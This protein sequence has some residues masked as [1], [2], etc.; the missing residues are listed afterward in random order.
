MRFVERGTLF[1]ESVTRQCKIKKIST[2]EVA[3]RSIQDE[4]YAE[5]DKFRHNTAS[6]YQNGE[7]VSKEV[8]GTSA[9][10]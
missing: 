2:F 7:I 4:E 9:T 1:L 10:Y 8:Q 5:T 3:T 6:H